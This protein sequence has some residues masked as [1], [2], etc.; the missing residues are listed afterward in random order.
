MNEQQHTL[1]YMYHLNRA[2]RRN[3]LAHLGGSGHYMCMNNAA[4]NA[5]PEH[6]AAKRKRKGARKHLRGTEGR[7]MCGRPITRRDP[8]WRELFHNVQLTTYPEGADTCDTCYR[9]SNARMLAEYEADRRAA[10]AAGRPF[11]EDQ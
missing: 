8:L 3:R 7:T 5:A 9:A 1:S 2:T 4:N 6:A 11:P 10:K